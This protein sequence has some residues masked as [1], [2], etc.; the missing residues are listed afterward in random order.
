M[1]KPIVTVPWAARKEVRGQVQSVLFVGPQP[2]LC[3]EVETV[4]DQVTAVVL[5]Q[6]WVQGITQGCSGQPEQ[7]WW[8]HS[9]EGAPC[10]TAGTA[11]VQLGSLH[12]GS[13]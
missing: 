6:S 1:E 3:A 11:A 7:H 9:A 8:V 10:G 2:C 4:Q 5:W 13:L 12:G